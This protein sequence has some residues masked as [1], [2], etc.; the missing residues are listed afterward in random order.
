ML[1]LIKTAPT[2]NEEAIK[3][4]CKQAKAKYGF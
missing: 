4:A 2:V 1:G 3:A